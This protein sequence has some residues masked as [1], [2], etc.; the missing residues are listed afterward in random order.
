MSARF[1]LARQQGLTEEM[2]Q[3]LP[4]YRDSTVFSEAEKVAI[5]YADVLA[6][7]HKSASDTLFDDLREHYN[8]SEILDLGWRIT[9]FIGYGRLIRALGLEIGEACPIGHPA[10]AEA[11]GPPA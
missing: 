3:A 4:R 10:G 2:V 7:D 11:A 5:R 8:E 6:G 1:A 9:S